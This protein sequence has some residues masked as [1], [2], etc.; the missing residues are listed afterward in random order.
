MSKLETAPEEKW[1]IA[2]AA[3]VLGVDADKLMTTQLFTI[4]DDYDEVIIREIIGIYNHKNAKVILDTYKDGVFEKA[5]KHIVN[6]CFS[7][8]SVNTHK[9]NYHTKLEPAKLRAAKKM[10]EWGSPFET[11]VYDQDITVEVI[12]A[13]INFKTALDSLAQA[14]AAIYG[15]NDL[16]T[17]GKNGDSVLKALRNNI[18][19]KDKPKVERLIKFIENHQKLTEDYINL[20]DNLGHGLTEHK[21]TISGFFKRKVD[22]EV[23]N[24][25]VQ[26]GDKVVD[27]GDLVD[28]CVKAGVEYVREVI[29][30]ILSSFVLGIGVGNLDGKYVWSH[31]FLAVQDVKSGKLEIGQHD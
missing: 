3:Q 5:H 15:F 31:E 16:K 10:E 19:D 7:L 23:Q 12:G 28:G 6:M 21:E 29:G 24:P 13:L 17:W 4:I 22:K 18:P 2:N 30:I 25:R 11:S 9:R 14:T 20:R 1:V 27:C 8:V 26:M